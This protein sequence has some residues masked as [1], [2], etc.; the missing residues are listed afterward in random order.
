MLNVKRILALTAALALA[1]ALLFIPGAD[2]ASSGLNKK[3]L[4]LR[5]GQ[6]YKLKVKKSK[7][8]KV[9]WSSSDKKVAS[10]SKKGK[11]KARK[12]GTAKITARA[13]KKKYICRVTVL[14][15]KKS[16][17][18]S[19]TAVPS[20]TAAPQTTA[21]PPT[22]AAPQTSEA[23]IP[24]VPDGYIEND[25]D[26]E[27]DDSGTLTAYYGEGGD[28]K[29]PDSVTSIDSSVFNGKD[30]TGVYIPVNVYSIGSRAFAYNF[31]L[32]NVIIASRRL[33][34]IGEEAFYNCYNLSILTIPNSVS[35][36]GYDAFCKVGHIYYYGPATFNTGVVYGSGYGYGSSS[37]R[38]NYNWGAY[39]RN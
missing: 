12:K 16:T 7:A 25:D 15:K 36:I 1:A 4:K 20:T 9:R 3:S 24:A 10:V 23:P 18:S 27:I 33:N 29:I 14:S 30:I 21:A 31:S 8:K 22:T 6:T 13:G 28:I 34:Y 37:R 39:A 19:G 2:M 26:Y 17:E 32:R 5:V 38:T 11:V 35:N